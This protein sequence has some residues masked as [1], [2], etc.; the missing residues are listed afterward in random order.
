MKERFL[1]VIKWGLILIIA[2]L[3]FYAVCPKY[4]FKSTSELFMIHRGNK[5]TGVIDTYAMS[6]GKWKKI[7]E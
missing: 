3:I 4:E 5:V 7:N 2:G 6:G 1:D